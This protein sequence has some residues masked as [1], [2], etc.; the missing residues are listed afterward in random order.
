MCSFLILKK[1]I[2]HNKEKEFLEKTI[3]ILN[4]IF[5]AGS[6]TGRIP[7]FGETPNGATK[8]SKRIRPFL[9]LLASRLYVVWLAS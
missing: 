1:E 8:R 4:Y 6:G 9:V 3:V 5:G 7:S 2:A